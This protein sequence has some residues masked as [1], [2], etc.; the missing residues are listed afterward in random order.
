MKTNKNSLS[1]VRTHKEM[2]QTKGE[3]FVLDEFANVLFRCFTLELPWKDNQRKISCIPAGRYKVVPRFSQRFNNHL[4][5]LDVP[6]RTFI[7]IHEANFVHQ[8]EGCIAVGA[9]RIDLN[10]DGKLDIT[11]SVITKNKILEFITG[12]TEIIIS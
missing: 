1:M 8:L 6:E 2:E 11:Q 12:P 10:G 7:L 5:I 9:S 3:L 4:H